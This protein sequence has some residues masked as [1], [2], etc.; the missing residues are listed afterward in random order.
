MPS[1]FLADSQKYADFRM[2]CCC[3]F[4]LLLGRFI[5]LLMW[6]SGQL[7][8]NCSLK[9]NECWYL[10]NFAFA[11]CQQYCCLSSVHFTCSA[12]ICSPYCHDRKFC[13]LSFCFG[14]DLLS[15]CLKCSQT[16]LASQSA[17]TC[18][19]FVSQIRSLMSLMLG[20]AADKLF[21]WL[22]GFSWC[23]NL[24]WIETGLHLWLAWETL[25]AV[26]VVCWC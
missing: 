8:R 16:G 26:V 1:C 11:R 18:C 14:S 13:A 21:R 17:L 3:Q 22:G 4:A 19:P 15:R 12:K 25:K 6:H 9:I 7:W 24:I 5:A 10:L 2:P 20:W 23:W